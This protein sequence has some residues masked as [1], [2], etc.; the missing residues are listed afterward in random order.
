[1]IKKFLLLSI[2]VMLSSQIYCKDRTLEG[3]YL[4]QNGFLGIEISVI[5]NN[6]LIQQ[7]VVMD[8]IV[9]KK[10]EWQR[11]FVKDI[12]NNN[13]QFY[14]LTGRREDNDVE[15]NGL[16]AY[17]LTITENGLEGFYY[18]P[19]NKNENRAGVKYIKSK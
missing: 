8:S 14:W 9:K 17:D 19:E 7:V 16:I 4:P 2:I 12:N 10:M 11:A 1:M 6:Y 15:S 18:F 13:I 5:G 3:L